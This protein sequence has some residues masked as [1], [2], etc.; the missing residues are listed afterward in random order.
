M[1]H[2]T[3][4]IGSLLLTTFFAHAEDDSAPKLIAIELPEDIKAQPISQLP[5]EK[6][7]Q[8]YF[9][10][11]VDSKYKKYQ[12]NVMVRNGHIILTNL[13]EDTIRANKIIAFVKRHTAMDV[14]LPDPL[15]SAKMRG[16]L[17][18][19]KGY[20]GIWL[21]QSTVLFPT[22][23]A[24][25]R[26]LSFSVGHR[27]GDKCGGKN[28]SAVSFGDQFPLYRWPSVW[29]WKGDLQLELEGGVFPVFCH[30]CKHSPMQ[31]A[32]YY[33]G[34]P[35][36]YAVGPW[37]FRAR[38]YHISTHLGDEYMEHQRSWKRKNKSFEAVDFFTAYKIND[39]ITVQGGPG[40]IFHSDKEYSIKPF[41]VEY[42]AEAR[43]FR[44]NF[45]QLYGQPFLSMYFRN[46]QQDNFRFDATYAVGYEWGKIQGLGRK[47]RLFLEY[48]DGMCVD[49][50]FSHKRS[51]FVA[52]RLSYGF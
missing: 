43:G 44:T 7:L 45:T 2:R 3:I 49:G 15:E 9:Q 16:E 47:I 23:V 10:G 38:L 48:H 33:A 46:Y 28:A 4:L 26:Q 39:N 13:P 14:V 37:A 36:S 42:G 22:N 17:V 12:V 40:C 34:I 41:Y 51:H 52:L 35:L 18:T 32:D 1:L 20:T 31:N 30:D 50:E 5:E 27:M 11:I 19:E 24:N 25:P 29:K 8:A 6:R 21:P